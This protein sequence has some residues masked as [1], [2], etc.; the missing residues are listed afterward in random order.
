M[1]R[2]IKAI[3]FDV[4]GT[5]LEGSFVDFV[6]NAYKV[7]GI[8][9]VFSV[10]KEV[11]FDSDF[12]KGLITGEECFRKFFSVPVLD[13]Q[14][15]EI[16]NIWT[17]TWVATDEMLDLV[18]NLKEHYK[19]AILSN[20]DLLNAEK[21]LNNGWYSCFDHLVLSHEV[22]I[23]KPDKRIYEITLN[24]LNLKAQD[25][26]FVDDQEDVLKPAREMGMETILFRSAEQLKREFDKK[27]ILFYKK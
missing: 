9:K 1:K 8:N 6:N 4:G 17:S 12:N 5:Y 27:N 25:C 7:L 19:L 14:M 10:D 11:C 22:G 15:E 24:K 16:K 13:E 2:E 26:L 23:L 3:I 20:S 21:F 18:K